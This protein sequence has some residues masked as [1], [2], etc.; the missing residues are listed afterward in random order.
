M[1]K[2]IVCFLII[3]VSYGFGSAQQV[4]S[5][6]GSVVKSELSVDWVLGGNLTDFFIKSQNS[7]K[8]LST[9]LPVDPGNSLKVYPSPAT[10]FV[11]IEIT[12]AD[13]GRL[14]CE[15]YNNSGVKV[16]VM[17]AVNQCLMKINV[18]EIPPGIYFLKVMSPQKEQLFNIEKIIKI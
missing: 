3:H 5:S 8:N 12:G 9:E 18:S 15:L 14:I 1:K 2:I 7:L 11:N 10:D 17:I 4:A 16:S 13:P 6:G